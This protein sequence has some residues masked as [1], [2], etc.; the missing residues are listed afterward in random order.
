MIRQYPRD[1]WSAE[2]FSVFL[3]IAL[4]YG[5]KGAVPFCL[6]FL[7]VHCAWADAA[8]HSGNC[9][10]SLPVLE[11]AGHYLAAGCRRRGGPPCP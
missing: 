5:P 4:G 10:S 3:G 6:S 11:Q 9:S 1:S 8:S 2:L 7:P